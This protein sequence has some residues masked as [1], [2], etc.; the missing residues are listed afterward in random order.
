MTRK[1]QKLIDKLREN[2][3]RPKPKSGDLQVWWIPQVPGQPFIV[4]VANLI[5]AKLLLDALAAYDLFQF[6]NRIKHDYANAGGLCVFEDGE[7]TD[8]YDSD[9]G[10]SI[11]EIAMQT[12]RDPDHPVIAAYRAIA[13][14][15]E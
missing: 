5:E 8:W 3:A 13:K 9:T 1:A 11:D 2:L 15:G 10:D 7:W 12:L 4:P 6:K 14:R